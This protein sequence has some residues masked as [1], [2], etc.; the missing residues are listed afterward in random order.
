MGSNCIAIQNK[1]SGNKVAKI[2]EYLP[3]VSV[4]IEGNYLG[5]QYGVPKVTLFRGRWRWAE[6][7]WIL[8]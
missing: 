7:G 5:S 1:I 3:L 6:Y 2:E 4:G 8:E